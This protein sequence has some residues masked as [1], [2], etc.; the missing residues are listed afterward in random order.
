MVKIVTGCLSFLLFPLLL[1]AQGSALSPDKPYEPGI[2][3]FKLKETPSAGGKGG[4]TKADA[5]AFLQELTKSIGAKSLQ[6][7]INVSSFQKRANGRSAKPHPLSQI[8]KMEIGEGM[9]VEE[10]V[11][12]LQSDKR[13]VYAEPYY[14][15][16]L[17]EEPDD[18]FFR[19]GNQQYLDNIQARDAWEIS[20][21]SSDV[22][23]GILDTGVNFAHP[24]LQDNLYLN[25]GE[26]P[27]DGI[28][29]DG[30]GFTDN[31]RGWDFANNDNDPTAD[32]DGHGTMVTGF[33]SASTNNDI[34]IAS[35]GYNCKYMPIKV[36]RS[37]NNSFRNGYEA[38]VYAAEM[39]CSILNLSWGAAGFRSQYVQDIINYVVL[40]KDVV[41]VAAAGNTAAELNFYPASYDNVLSVSSSNYSD[42]KASYATWSSYVDLLAPGLNVFSTKNGGYG[43]GSGTSYAS[44][45]VAGAAALLR[46]HFPELNALQIMQRL[47]MSADDVSQVEGNEPYHEKIGK[48]RLNMARALAR[49]VSPAVRMQQFDI[50]NGSGPFAFYNDTLEI[51]MD[52]VNFLSPTTELRISLTTNSPYVTAIDSVISFAAINTLEGVRNEN[53]PFR[54]YLHPD[55]PSDEVIRFR[56]GYSDI[57]YSDYQF[58]Q[59]HTSGSYLDFKVDQL[60]LTLSSNG[61]LGYNSDY[62]LQGIGFR[63]QNT[64]L[65]HNLGLVIAQST[66]AVANNALQTISPAV[67][68]KDFEA[69]DRLK[70]YNNSTAFRDA[71]SVFRTKASAEAPLDLLVE[72]KIL[73]WEDTLSSASFVLEYRIIN[74][75]DTAYEQLHT[76]LFADFDIKEFYSNRAAWDQEHLLGYAYDEEESQFAGIA[77]LSNHGAGF[78][79]LD[80]ASRNGNQT[81]VEDSLSRA[82]KYNYLA[83][84]IGKQSA[85]AAGSGNDVAQFLGG[86]IPLLQ[87]NQ[88]EKI[89]FAL[90]TAQTLI[91][92]QQEVAI[93]RDR[94]TAYL[95]TPPL[96]AQLLACPGNNL[97]VRPEGGEQFFFY[98]DPFGN[99]LI[100][101]G[102]SL[103]LEN[104]QADTT[105]YIANADLPY[106]GDIERIEILVREPL[107]L[108]SMSTDTL[109]VKAG[110][111]AML[112]LTDLSEF[113]GS[114]HWNFNNGYTSIKQSPKA[115]FKTAGTYTIRLDMTNLAGCADS[116]SRQLVVVYQEEAP[117]ISDQLL[118]SPGTASLQTDDFSIFNLYTD[119]EKQ[120]K[121]FEGS[122]FESSTLHSDTVF[123]AS[124]GSG[125]YES[126]LT[127]VSISLFDAGLSVVYSLD[128]TAETTY[129]IRLQ[130]NVQ[131]ADL[132]ARL[133]WYINGVLESYDSLLQWP[134]SATDTL[135]N[136]RAIVYYSNGCQASSSIEIKLQ[137]SPAP[138]LSD[139]YSCKG[140][141]PVIRPAED[142]LYYF[143]SDAT[144]NKLMHKGRE[145]QAEPLTASQTF[146]VSNV[147]LGQESV[148]VAVQLSVPDSLAYFRSSI[149]TLGLNGEGIVSFHPT[150]PEIVEW[151]WDFGDGF[152]SDLSEPEHL[153]T[154]PGTYTVTLRAQS[155]E[156]CTNT[157][158]RSL[159][160][161]Q[162]T[163]LATENERLQQLNTYPN[164]A[165][166]F[167][168]LELPPLYENAF[169]FLRSLN[170][171]LIT[172][173]A[174]QA[175]KPLLR[176]PVQDLPPGMYVLQLQTKKK[177]FVSRFSKN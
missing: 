48:G 30:D 85:G 42:A 17:L 15:P 125:F 40:E 106:P 168:L 35:T 163:G 161:V 16:E 24:D 6:Q 54:I 80:I 44:P 27:N 74:T 45:Q 69:R 114:W 134:Y 147:S 121:I 31:Y 94:Y 29:N 135:I 165:G 41:I 39:G 23:I 129:G 64:P 115:Y 22:I 50:F 96:H 3:V 137:P 136:A 77:L 57:N 123:Y 127:P 159:L 11:K 66:G 13:I 33:S 149:D 151:Q 4:R 72:Q 104:L 91:E 140:S 58:F 120:Q 61:N 37:E 89:A 65:A 49:E 47:R 67:R 122:L 132:A 130:A 14:L 90:V 12:R 26:I 171:R 25:T 164:P 83:G 174:V 76:G 75:A 38:M 88:T 124:Q 97:E 117:Q 19:E 98:S 138:V 113:P 8:Y 111:T 99:N 148:A 62:N 139:L 71:R 116:Y 145:Y 10:V 51:R 1:F 133:E 105:F 172:S 154:S 102:S 92:L 9:E 152:T 86:T 156:G 167:I 84:G 59:L 173:Q 70:L 177:V 160:V 73:G 93:A 21:G 158:S 28:D 36:F 150:N 55:L 81:E 32:R 170:G 7:A 126:A 110:E 166:D 79:A 87:P 78:H 146:Y 153:Y 162:T 131:Q 60:I 128:S 103:L 109:S 56:L 20:Q 63:H 101:E 112:A 155:K 175:G 118:C 119:A 34:G 142:G 141:S 46:S 2:V 100:S 169:L 82:D 144:Q 18:E 5:S 157:F 108:F 143:Y 53:E 68:N 107:A 52:F 176:L 43:T 95:R